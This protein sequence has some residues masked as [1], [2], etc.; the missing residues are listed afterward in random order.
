MAGPTDS[1]EV[2]A[3]KIQSLIT[4]SQVSLS[5]ADVWYGEQRKIPR[6]PT[7]EIITGQKVRN[8]AG[9]PRRSKNSFECFV[10]VQAGMVQDTQLNLHL[11]GQLAESIEAILHADPT[12]GGIC[13]NSMVVRTE[14]GVAERSSTQYRA[15]RL[16]VVGE[17]LTLLPMQPNYNQ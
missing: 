6:T 16:T 10:M 11:A 14:F 3:A 1:L 7:V 13:I 17:S 15:A 5:I 2:F 8:L 4:A 9:A 12:L